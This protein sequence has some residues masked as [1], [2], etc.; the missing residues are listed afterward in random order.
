MLHTP[1]IVRHVCKGLES[2]KIH[3]F[4]AFVRHDRLSVHA[5]E[6]RGRR[7]R[8]RSRLVISRTA[9]VNYRLML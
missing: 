5:N 2:T 7:L 9:L 8:E 3:S 4:L 6:G 1:D